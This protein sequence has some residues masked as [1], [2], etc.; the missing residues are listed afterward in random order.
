[1][2]LMVIASGGQQAAAAV[3]SIAQPHPTLEADL[4]MRE[5]AA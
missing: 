2:N 1:M 4:D 3:V 5:A